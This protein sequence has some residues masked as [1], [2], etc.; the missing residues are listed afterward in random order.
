MKKQQKSVQGGYICTRVRTKTVFCGAVGA[1][2]NTA[3]W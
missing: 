3:F 2:K 1:S